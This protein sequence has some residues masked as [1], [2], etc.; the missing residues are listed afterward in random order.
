MNELFSVCV[1]LACFVQVT[2]AQ[3]NSEQYKTELDLTQKSLQDIQEQIAV[4]QNRI[5][6]LKREIAVVE[7]KNALLNSESGFSGD[8]VEATLHRISDLLLEHKKVVQIRNGSREIAPFLNVHSPSAD[9]LRVCNTIRPNSIADCETKMNAISSVY[10]DPA[11]WPDNYIFNKKPFF[12]GYCKN[13]KRIESPIH[14]F[15]FS[16]SRLAAAFS[17][18]KADK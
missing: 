9:N 1:L 17:Y 4:E 6:E 5:E 2:V 3:L 11:H 10:E 18:N 14:S 16:S 12:S 15:R 8:G 13:Q 7:K